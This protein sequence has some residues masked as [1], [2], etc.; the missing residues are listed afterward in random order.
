MDLLN[1]PYKE[2]AANEWDKGM[3][4]TSCADLLTRGTF[5]C[6]ESLT[7]DW[8]EVSGDGY[9]PRRRQEQ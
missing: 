3:G 7:A 4:S 2:K 5:H 8:G 9:E 1:V 6:L